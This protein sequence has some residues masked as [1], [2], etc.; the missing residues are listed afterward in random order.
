MSAA[1]VTGV[2]GSQHLDCHR[3]PVLQHITIAK[4]LLTVQMVKMIQINAWWC[5]L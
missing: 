1:D 4:R 2:C 5:G 3:L